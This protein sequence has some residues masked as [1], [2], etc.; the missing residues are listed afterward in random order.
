MRAQEIAM[1]FRGFLLLG[2]PCAALLPNLTSALEVDRAVLPRLAVGGRALATPTFITRD[3]FGSEDD[4]DSSEIDVSDSALLFRFDKRI[5][6]QAGVA[7]GVVGFRKTSTDSE[8]DDVFF[9]QLNAFFWNQDFEATVGQTRL[10]NILIEFP[11]IRDE[12]LIE[13]LYVPNASSYREAEED[14]L[15]ATEASFDWFVDRKNHAL[16][17]WAAAR[18]ETDEEGEEKELAELNT[19][20]FGWVYAGPEALQYVNPVR[21]AGVLVDIQ[22][23]DDSAADVDDNSYSVMAGTELNLNRNP[24]HVWAVG[25]Q[26]L[27]HHG[28]DDVSFDPAASD[29][30]R[31][32][33]LRRAESWA[34]A[35]SGQDT[36]RPKLLTRAAASLTLAYKDYPDE[37]DATQ[38]SAAPRFLYRLGHA[39]DIV[40]QYLY[41]WRDDGLAAMTGFD[42]VHEIQIGLSFGFDYVFNDQIGERQSLTNLE[43]GYIQ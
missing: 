38:F 15:F 40:A 4:D 23:V 36:W 5:Y 20:G 1:R 21:K 3:G 13:Y 39:I 24:Q 26:G 34:V 8:E 11:T 2:V 18:I 27:Y 42:A 37:D 16:S 43:H 41:T 29:G 32:V 14:Q 9:H 10:R 28:I 19:L 33:A 22:W 6:S 31:R 30:A 7:G 12:D 17:V 35:A 25:A